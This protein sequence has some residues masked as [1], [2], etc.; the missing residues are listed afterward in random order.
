MES[1]A[2]L[3]RV[4][5]AHFGDFALGLRPA[6]IHREWHNKCDEYHRL[7]LKAPVEHGKSTQLTVARPLY[8]L[9]RNPDLRCAIISST[10]GQSCKWLAK[11]KI[12]IE[13]NPRVA[14]VFPGLRREARAG[15]QR[16]WYENA[17]LVERSERAAMLEK[18]YSIQATGVG[19]NILG[20][21]LD[22][23]IM[24]DVLDFENTLSATQRQKIYD[25]FHSVLL[26]R[27]VEGGRL[28][29]IGTAWHEDDLVHRLA[30]EK[31][32]IYHVA[33]YEA[34]VEPCLW[35]ERWS[36]KRLAEK[37]D[38]LGDVEYNRQF[39]NIPLGEATGYFPLEFFRAC[40]E[41][42]QDPEEWWWG[43][44]APGTFFWITAGVDLGGSTTGSPSAVC[45]AGQ[46]S[47][48][49]RKHLLHLRSGF[50]IGGELLAELLDVNRQHAINEWIVE[51]NAAQL[52][53][54]A[55]LGNPE[56]LQALGATQEEA[57][58]IN[59][60]AQ[61]TTEY[62]KNH[63]RWGVRGLAPEFRAQ[64]WSIPRGQAEVGNL[65]EELRRYTPEGHT[66]D[67][68]IALWLANCRLQ[69]QGQ[70]IP[71]PARSVLIGRK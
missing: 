31:P 50:W 8:E 35:P 57:N 7:I 3:A 40:Q 11:I 29:I 61:F 19:G 44:Y 51:S 70:P 47:A 18:D 22:L 15:Y 60:Y 17:I 25:W 12:N 62:N 28:W 26:G 36:T 34:G 69:G 16:A 52:H 58:T 37:R 10:M 56:I 2:A 59:V 68:L 43:S 4:S 48:D 14:M 13:H 49:S 5:P 38:E 6:P 53:L 64:Q 45:V 23:I 24:D 27:L 65:Q 20:S 41:Q 71:T 67:R 63:I 21:R 1:W 54:A 46:H 42:C 66:G 39:R 30:R 32:H 55:M 33:H 9:G